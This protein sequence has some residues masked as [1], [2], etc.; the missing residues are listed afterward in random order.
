M[1]PHDPENLI[2]QSTV[3][4]SYVFI[5]CTVRKFYNNISSGSNSSSI[6]S[7]VPNIGFLNVTPGFYFFLA[8]L[9]GLS[10]TFQVF[11]VFTRVYIQGSKSG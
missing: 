6:H 2:L 1:M 4:G 9:S 11:A 8:F 3:K 5:V 10:P 7:S